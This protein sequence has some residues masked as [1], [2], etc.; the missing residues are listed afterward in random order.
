MNKKMLIFVLIIFLFS[1]IVSAQSIMITVE[2]NYYSPGDSGFKKIYGKSKYFPEGK[3]ALRLFGNVYIWGSCGFFSTSYNWPEWSNKGVIESDIEGENVFDKLIISG[4]V[5]YYLGFIRPN[6][7]AIKLEVGACSITNS[8]DATK[9]MRDSGEIV[10][11]SERE[12]SGIGLRGNLGVSYGLLKNI[13]AEA[14]VGY[15]YVTDKVDDKR[16]NLGGLRLSLGLGV[17]F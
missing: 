7:F 10:S 2:G 15:L 1:I 12:E 5:G 6:D 13:F 14:S 9:T 17:A 8:I 16:I 3:I 11:F 4:G